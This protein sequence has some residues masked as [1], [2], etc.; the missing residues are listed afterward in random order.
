MCEIARNAGGDQ[1]NSLQRS[2]YVKTTARQVNRITRRG[3]HA[4]YF[5]RLSNPFA[6]FLYAHDVQTPK[7]VFH[8]NAIRAAMITITMNS[9]F[10]TSEIARNAG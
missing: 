5:T 9:R 1:W 3:R 8:A 4:P 2:A 7:G 10:M 6:I